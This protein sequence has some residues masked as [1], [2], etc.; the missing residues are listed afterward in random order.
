MFWKNALYITDTRKKMTN[1]P[2]IAQIS[3]HK[4]LKAIAKIQPKGNELPMTGLTPLKAAV[5]QLYPDHT[6]AFTSIHHARTE[7]KALGFV[8]HENY[9]HSLTEAGKE[10]LRELEAV[11]AKKRTTTKT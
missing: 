7:A 8:V 9:M 5:E 3:L 10:K 6:V 11:P 4:L 2:V 1:K